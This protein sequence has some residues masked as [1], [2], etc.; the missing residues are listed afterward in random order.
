MLFRSVDLPDAGLATS[1]FYAWTGLGREA[2]MVFFVLS[3]FLVGGAVMRAGPAFDWRTYA[4]AR[5]S[6]LWVVLVPALLLTAALDTCVAS[7][8]PSILS[9]SHYADW[10]SGPSPQ[11]LYAKDWLTALGNLLFLQTLVVPV[12]GTNTPLWSLA[13]ESWYYL[14]FPL[15]ASAAGALGGRASWRIAAGVAE[16]GRAHV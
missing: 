15:A 3:G 10:Q 6:R 7:S 1:L 8:W 14:W 12:F 4:I 9:G 16:I 2:V 13:N 11:G 5:L